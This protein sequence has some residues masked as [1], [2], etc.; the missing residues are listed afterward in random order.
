MG[1]AG[2]DAHAVGVG[3]VDDAVDVGGVEGAV[4]AVERDRV[5]TGAGSVFDQIG[6]GEGEAEDQ[7]FFALL[8]FGEDGVGEHGGALLGDGRVVGH[9]L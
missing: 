9:K 2:G 1:H 7:G 4:L 6:V 5:E 3:D 8:V